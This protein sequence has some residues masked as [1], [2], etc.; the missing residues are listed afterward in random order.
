M[1][2]KEAREEGLDELWFKCT[3]RELMKSK[4]EGEVF[5]SLFIACS[6]LLKP[7]IGLL[8]MKT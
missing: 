1:F 3:R 2:S 8:T 7:I 5:P 4:K 6:S